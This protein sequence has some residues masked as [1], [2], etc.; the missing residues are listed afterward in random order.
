[1]NHINKKTFQKIAKK[2]IDDI[3]Y[4]YY[5]ESSA[6]RILNKLKTRR[7]FNCSDEAPHQD[8]ID[9]LRSLGISDE[10]IRRILEQKYYADIIGD[11]NE[12]SK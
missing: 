4:H 1:M 5:T 3:P 6:D 8:L 9:E 10:Q 2:M 11:E 7:V 12:Q